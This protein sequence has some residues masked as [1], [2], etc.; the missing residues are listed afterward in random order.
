MSCDNC[1]WDEFVERCSETLER[2]E[3]LPERARDFGDSCAEKVE[4]MREWAAEHQHVT[5]KM[6]EALDNIRA[7]VGR[8]LQE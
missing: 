3:E 4:G 7:G 1:D 2:C 8:W 5:E 6:E